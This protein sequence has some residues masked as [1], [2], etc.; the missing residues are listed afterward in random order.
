MVEL[1]WKKQQ[2]VHRV[3]IE[4]NDHPIWIL[5]PAF[6]QSLKRMRVCLGHNDPLKIKAAVSNLP[7]RFN[8]FLH[9]VM[10]FKSPFYARVPVQ[11]QKKK[12][13]IPFFSCTATGWKKIISRFP[14]IFVQYDSREKT[15]GPLVWDDQRSELKSTEHRFE[16]RVWMAPRRSRVDYTWTRIKKLHWDVRG[17][18]DAAAPRL[19]FPLP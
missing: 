3:R 5:A 13:K 7:L 6:F 16:W 18:K 11:K 1:S 10:R 19:P 9:R 15:S 12:K 17:T 4:L 8:P 14:L 2:A